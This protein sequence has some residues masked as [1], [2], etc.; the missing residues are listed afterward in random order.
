MGEADDF[1]RDFPCSQAGAWL[2]ETSLE[3]ECGTGQERLGFQVSQQ[4]SIDIS[5]QPNDIIQVRVSLALPGSYIPDGLGNGRRDW[6][7]GDW[8]RVSIPGPE[9][10]KRA[11]IR[12]MVGGLERMDG[13]WMVLQDLKREIWG[14]A[15][16]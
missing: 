11:L 12:E 4:E 9:G 7:Q 1:F 2:L 13:I 16:Y 10:R 6:R 3:M 5:D 14:L 15:S 8:L